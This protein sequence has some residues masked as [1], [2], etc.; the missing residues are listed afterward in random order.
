MTYFL[1]IQ[2]LKEELD[3]VQYTRY[4]RDVEFSCEYFLSKTAS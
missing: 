3:S 4:I 2:D 1:T